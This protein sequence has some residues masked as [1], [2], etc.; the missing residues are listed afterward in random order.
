M[1]RLLVFAQRPWILVWLVFFIV[2]CTDNPEMTEPVS[3][4]EAEQLPVE[5][6]DFEPL[7]LLEEDDD[8]LDDIVDNTEPE[9][10]PEPEEPFQGATPVYFG[11][12][13]YNITPDSEVLLAQLA[14]YLKDNLDQTLKIEGH[15]DERGT[16]EYNLALGEKRALSVMNFLV[17]LG[18]DPTRMTATSM[19]EESPAVAGSDSYSWS[20]NRRV[21]FILGMGF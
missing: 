13:Q 18:V 6:D 3:S 21:E 9:F 7:P 2:R 14:M 20:Q 12:D 4:M 19:G 16:I 8:V 11:F 15:C 5:E 10:M 17:N 1:S